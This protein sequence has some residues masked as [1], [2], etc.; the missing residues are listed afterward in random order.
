VDALLA[1]DATV[2]AEDAAATR[3]A[4]AAALLVATGP[5]TRTRLLTVAGSVAKDL[6]DADPTVLAALAGA[7]S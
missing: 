7:G 3:A 4:L 5:R 6:E 2:W 1:L